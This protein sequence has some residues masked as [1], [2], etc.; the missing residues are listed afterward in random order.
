MQ[1]YYAVDS[2]MVVA[3]CQFIGRHSHIGKVDEKYI[4]LTLFFRHITSLFRVEC[5]P[6]DYSRY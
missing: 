1:E 5:S 2:S 6:L 4:R 3:K